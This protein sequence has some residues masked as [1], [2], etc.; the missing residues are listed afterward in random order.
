MSLLKYLHWWDS[1]AVWGVRYRGCR[2]KE[3][4]EIQGRGG[5]PRATNDAT[6]LERYAR[7][8]RACARGDKYAM[9]EGRK[10]LEVTI[11][12]PVSIEHFWIAIDSQRRK[13]VHHSADVI[14]RPGDEHGRRKDIRIT[15]LMHCPS[16]SMPF[17]SNS[18]PCPQ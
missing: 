17:K 7:R 4:L 5:R 8:S 6:T 10:I 12:I 18:T 13:I 1:E 2:L 14:A 11:C 9:S 16:A 3:G 15:N